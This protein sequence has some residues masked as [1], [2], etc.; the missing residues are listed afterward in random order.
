ML[1]KDYKQAKAE[2]DAIGLK[3]EHEYDQGLRPLKASRYP[4]IL[5]LPAAFLPHL[6]GNLIWAALMAGGI[7][8]GLIGSRLCR[9]AGRNF[10]G[11]IEDFKRRHHQ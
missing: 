4:F 5:A 9:I 2:L 11:A 8:M 7:V 3:M 6:W 10:D 1:K